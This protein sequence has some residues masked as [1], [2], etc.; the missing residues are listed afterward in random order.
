[1]RISLGESLGVALGAVWSQRFRSALTVLGI[2]IGITT[3]V[4]VASLLAGLRRGIVT[5]FQQMGPDNIF[6]SQTRS[7]TD[8]FPE[9]K[10]RRRRPI[11]PEYAEIIRRLCPLVED[12][13]TTLLIPPVLD[14]RPLVARARR[15]ETDSLTLAGAS[16]NHFAVSPRELTAGRLFTPEEERRGARVA[17]LGATIA[18]TLFPGGQAVGS[19]MLVDGGEF[20]VLGVFTKAQGSFFGEN[21]LDRQVTIPLRTARMRY[22]Q[23]DRF[24]ITAKARPQRRQDT[25]EEVESL[26]RRLRRTPPGQENDFSLSTP[27]QV[28]RQ[29]DRMT[30]LIVLSSLAISGLGLLVGGIGV[31]NIMLV[32]V[33]ERTREIG[34]RKAIG[35]RRRDITAQFLLEAVA[36]T[37]TGGIL[38][39]ITALML[40][41]LVGSLVL[42]LPNE[43]S[44]WALLIGFAV[45]VLVGVFFGVWP[46]LKAA[47][48]DPVVALRYE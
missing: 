13:S 1:M 41:L 35:A 42:S 3:V 10:E 5:F 7:P 20:I 15:Y 43:V 45:S 32:S 31:M 30:R 24:L 25:Y 19:A 22:P 40:S 6:L 26:L 46:A 17:L 36:L 8:P 21:A 27:D 39:V 9:P 34:L 44:L 12:A 29:F 18:E 37:G 14:G 11:R 38:G 16:A 47:R 4:T 33:T 23:L 48:L 28:I 2:V